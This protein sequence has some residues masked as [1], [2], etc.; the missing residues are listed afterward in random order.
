M[1]TTL[2]FYKA[3]GRWQDAAVRL[4]TRSR[5]SHCELVAIQ[6]Q[7]GGSA[8]A[9]SA[10]KRDGNCVRERRIEFHRGHW[11]FARVGVDMSEAWGRALDEIGFPYDVFRAALS[12][13]PVDIN[14]DRGWFCSELCAYAIGLSR[15]HTYSPGDLAECCGLPR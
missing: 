13:L 2:A 7:P 9:V 4:I 1:H 12:A 14:S 5:F 10:S 3:P 8:R 15:P 11:E 6:P